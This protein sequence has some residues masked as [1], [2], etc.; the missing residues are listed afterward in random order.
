MVGKI[1]R[2]DMGYSYRIKKHYVEISY[3]GTF[4]TFVLK[5]II[6]LLWKIV[7]NTRVYNIF[8]SNYN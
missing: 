4:L 5:L 7:T 1:I 8:G 3:K 6:S 2:N